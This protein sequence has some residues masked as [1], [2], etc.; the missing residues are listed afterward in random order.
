[1][2]ALRSGFGVGGGGREDPQVDQGGDVP[3]P[4]EA[5]GL[6]VGVDQLAAGRDR[7][8][9][10]D[11]GPG[12]RELRPGGEGRGT[13]P[14]SPDRRACGEGTAGEDGRVARAGCWVVVTTVDKG[15]NQR[16]LNGLRVG[17][18]TLLG[19]GI[20]GPTDGA[21]AGLAAVKER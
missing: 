15:S 5:G 21:S 3:D 4:A 7:A 9:P 14:A 19:I 16:K 13:A 17:V 18:R 1:M 10:E 6:A 8:G 12:D 2:R 11:G 20:C